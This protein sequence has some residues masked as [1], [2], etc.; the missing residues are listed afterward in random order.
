M[1][2]L[3]RK[4]EIT[5]LN[6][7]LELSAEESHSLFRKN[8]VL[9]EKI[10]VQ[11]SEFASDTNNHKAAFSKLVSKDREILGVF[12]VVGN[13]V[14]IAG[15]RHSMSACDVYYVTD[16]H[17]SVA[18][19]YIS[20][21]FEEHNSFLELHNL[22]VKASERGKDIGT[23]ILKCIE[24]RACTLNDTITRLEFTKSICRILIPDPLSDSINFYRKFGYK[25]C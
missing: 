4:S 1:F 14:L 11:S 21:Y 12:E 9:E 22:E 18:D 13:L 2:R 23:A 6:Q 19:F 15:S 10:S 7:S 8:V 25:D 20:L 24:L 16:L 17:S 3:V 5:R